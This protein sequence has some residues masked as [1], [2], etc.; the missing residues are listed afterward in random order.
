MCSFIVYYRPG[1]DRKE[2]EKEAQK[3]VRVYQADIHFMEGPLGGILQQFKEK[4][5]K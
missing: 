4:A 1:Y 2:L 5:E 3:A